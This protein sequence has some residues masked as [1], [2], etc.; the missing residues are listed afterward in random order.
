[1][2]YSESMS[3][4]LILLTMFPSPLDIAPYSAV[5][6]KKLMIKYTR[7]LD[8]VQMN[9]QRIAPIFQKLQAASTTQI[10]IAL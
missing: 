6:V 9:G 7:V 5:R 10:A 4:N 8:H 2:K 3:S 1:M